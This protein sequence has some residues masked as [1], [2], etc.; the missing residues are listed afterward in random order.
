MTENQEIRRGLARRLEFIEWRVY[1][2]GRVNRRDLEE[3]F[4]IST[5]QASLDFREYQQ[6]APHNIVYNATEK[7]FLASEF[8]QPIFMKLSPE[9]YLLQLQA[10]KLEA[11]PKTDTW[12]AELPPSEVTPTIVRGPKVYV[13]R[14]ILRAIEMRGAIEINYQ[15]LSKSGMRRVCPHALVHDGF[16]WH[17]RA[18]CLK[19]LEYRDYVLGRVHSISPPTQFGADSDDDL[20]WNT[21]FSLN[22]IAHPDLS[23]QQKSAIEDD[24]RMTDGTLTLKMRLAVAYYFVKRYNLDLVHEGKLDPERAQLCLEN[25]EDL[26]AAREAAKAR[27][28]E[29]IALRKARGELTEKLNRSSTSGEQ[30]ERSN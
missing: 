14:G 12:F 15:S 29:L 25:Y 1:W 17:M 24:Y 23:A 5:P 21:Q 2:A 11:T 28:K 8:F 7:T 30:A 27:S 6:L 26:Q 18:L 19:N 3:K 16:R 20:E 22:L 10:L 4:D 13:L 9:R